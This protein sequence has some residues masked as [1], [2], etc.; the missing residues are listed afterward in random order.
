MLQI[1]K[2]LVK[3]IDINGNNNISPDIDVKIPI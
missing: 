3:L 1:K 2:E